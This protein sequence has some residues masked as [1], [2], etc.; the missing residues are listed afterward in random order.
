M[1]REASRGQLYIVATP[2]GNLS[3]ISVRALD[4][5]RAV[6]LIAAEDT[7]HSSRLLRHFGID[8]PMLSLHEH[9]ERER[10]E[11]L[12]TRID[13]GEQVALISDAG[14]PLISDPGFP[15][16]RAA[17]ERG[18]SVV[19]IP[20]PSSLLAALSAAGLPTDRFYFE[21]F[22]PAAAGERRRRIT[23]LATLPHSVVLLLPSHRI[24]AGVQEL[25]SE[26][27]GERLAVL[28]KELTKSHERI[29]R[30][31]LRQLLD[32]L[33]ADPLHEKGEFVVILSGA[34]LSEQEIDEQERRG[35]LTTLLEELPP[36]RAARVAAKILGGRPN[37][38]YSVALA[39]KEEGRQE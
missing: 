3:D 29:I 31:P 8:T 30:A 22:L 35:L 28:A 15:L 21:G 10:I 17:H 37:E 18:V 11:S 4:T 1:K 39:L 16:V 32:W 20:G 24:R 7:R 33:D 14:T 6:D 26:L 36:K 13:L 19:P 23:A 12:L 27:G 9:N 2:I 34:S 25:I 5:L 38:L